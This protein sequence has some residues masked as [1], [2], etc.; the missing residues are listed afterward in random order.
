MG[1][2]SAVL[3]EKNGLH[4]SFWTGRSHC[5]NCKKTLKWYELIPLIS[6]SLQSGKCRTC[7]A[8]IP[9]WIWFVEWYM[10]FLWMIVAML[11]SLI[12]FSIF[13]IALH[14]ILLTWLSLLVIEDMRL[15]TISDTRSIP[16][17]VCIVC[18]FILLA[19]CPTVT[20]L[21]TFLGALVG[22]LVGMLFYMIQMMLPAMYGA[23]RERR[24]MDIVYI[25]GS[26]IIFPLWLITKMII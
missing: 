26:P 5:L 4:R 22:A 2:F 14:I 19:Y 15:R 17:M 21:P 12:G 16:L 13:S 11:L 20:L 25:L 23:W 8:G 7:G 6:Y 3:L 1:S 10:A 9:R 18:V 24:Y